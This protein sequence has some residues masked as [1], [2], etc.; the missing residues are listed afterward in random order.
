MSKKN[1]QARV[2]AGSDNERYSWKSY[3]DVTHVSAVESHC[4][5]HPMNNMVIETR[6]EG[7]ETIFEHVVRKLI[8]FEVTPTRG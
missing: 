7:E 1:T 5:K 2:K 3:G 6:W 4:T 8:V